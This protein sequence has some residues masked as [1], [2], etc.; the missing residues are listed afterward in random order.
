VTGV[1]TC[2][3]PISALFHGVG[4]FDL[5]TGKVHKTKGAPATY[6]AVFG[7][8]L[9]KM[10]ADD[11]RIVAITAAMPDGTGLGRFA[12]EFPERFFDV[13]I[14]EQHGVTFAAGL[15]T[16]GLKPVFA[17]YSSFLQ[18]GYDQVIHD[19]CLQ[20]LPVVFAID[21]AGVV[22]SD[23][24]THHGVFDISYLRPIPG[25]TIM[26]PKDENELQ[27]MLF[28]ALQYRRPVAIRY[29]RGSGLGV[30]LEQLLRYIPEGSAEVVRQAEP[31][32]VIIAVGNMVQTALQAADLLAEEGVEVSVINA[33]FIKPLDRGR[34]LPLASNSRI[35]TVEDNALQGGFGSALLELFEEEGLSP[36]SVI[37]IGY[38]DS[39]IEQGEQ[40]ELYQRYGLT[41]TAIAARI[42]SALL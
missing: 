10:A 11:E 42:R 25:L 41:C 29:P 13:G 33:R 18:R 9:C 26:A 6:T 27:H 19:V 32:V 40:A 16:E 37:R 24:P 20:D 15:A 23:G 14:A 4:P 39:F 8:T 30:P 1:Q 22:G 35:F 34:I 12:K 5:Q 3:L 2:A 21:R 36:L 7:E 28:S 31:G 17:I 38:P